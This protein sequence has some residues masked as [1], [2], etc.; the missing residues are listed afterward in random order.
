MED[1]MDVDMEGGRGRSNKRDSGNGD[2]NWRGGRRFIYR[3]KLNA[4]HMQY[5][6]GPRTNYLQD[7]RLVR[8]L[9]TY[10]IV[11]CEGTAFHVRGSLRIRR[12]CLSWKD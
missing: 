6:S 8:H 1:G 10:Q 11:G 5:V 7:I 4:H 12:S 3:D 2:G 9:P